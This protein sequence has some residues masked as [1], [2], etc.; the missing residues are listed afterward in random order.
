MKL[1]LIILILVSLTGIAYAYVVTD[2][3]CVSDCTAKG[4]RMSQCKDSCL[5][6]VELVRK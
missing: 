6:E 3:Q 5:A 1:L 4:G 2:W